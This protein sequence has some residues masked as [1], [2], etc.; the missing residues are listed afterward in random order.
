MIRADRLIK[1]RRRAMHRHLRA[2]D[3]RERAV[4][5][6]RRG[7]IEP[8]PH[9]RRMQPC[10]V[11]GGA[12]VRVNQ[13]VATAIWPGCGRAAITRGSNARAVPFSASS[14]S[15]P[16]RSAIRHVASPS[17]TVSPQIAVMCWVP[18]SSVS[19]SLGGKDEQA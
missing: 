16:A 13:N 8:R 7:S 14:E 17:S 15:A 6:E 11:V 19:P 9:S 2:S 5:I 18:L 12:S 3:T 1:G 4:A 10:V